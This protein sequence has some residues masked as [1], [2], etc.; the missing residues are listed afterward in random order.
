MYATRTAAIFILD[1]AVRLDD[2][3]I[4]SDHQRSRIASSV[5]SGDKDRFKYMLRIIQ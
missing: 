1:G 5:A 4:L 2:G 3:F